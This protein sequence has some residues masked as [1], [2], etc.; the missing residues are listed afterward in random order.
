MHQSIDKKNKIAIYLIL[1]LILSTISSKNINSQ[2]SLASGISNLNV[3]GLSYSNN[4][5]IANKLD[6][7]L[8]EYSNRLNTILARPHNTAETGSYRQ[9]IVQ[10][11]SL[12][13]R[14]SRE[15][16]QIGDECNSAQQ[17]FLVADQEKRKLKRLAQKTL[18]KANQQ[19]NL[20]ETK[21]IEAQNLI[22]FNLNS[23]IAP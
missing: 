23:R 2:K 7:L 13:E 22:Q 8:I 15:L 5:L 3:E 11:Q 6:S 4:L 16:K 21:D 12:Q 10:L 1:L 17:K 9:F 14:T 18:E 19:R 20:R